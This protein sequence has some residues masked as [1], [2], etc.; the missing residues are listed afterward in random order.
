MAEYYGRYNVS[1]HQNRIKLPRSLTATLAENQPSL[2][3]VVVQLMANDLPYLAVYDRSTFQARR[4]EIEKARQKDGT[5]HIDI[6]ETR[7]KSGNIGY[8]RDLARYA[9]IKDDAIVIG[10]VL[11]IEIWNKDY[12]EQYHDNDRKKQVEEML[13]EV[14]RIHEAK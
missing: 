6:L 11:W 10:A 14:Q 13:D 2:E 8:R 12:F 3:I 1:S 7:V 9:H 4:K 5:E